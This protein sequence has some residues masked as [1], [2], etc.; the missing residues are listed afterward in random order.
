MQ[1]YIKIWPLFTIEQSNSVF[2]EADRDGQYWQTQHDNR[3]D[4]FT[5]C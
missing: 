2:K 3:P 5:K 1:Y 4:F